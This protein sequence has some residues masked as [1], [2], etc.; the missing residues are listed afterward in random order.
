V[1]RAKGADSGGA[2]PETTRCPPPL[3]PPGC[4][5]TDFKFMPLLVARLRDSDLASEQTPEENWAAVL[6]WAASWHQVPAGSL[7]NVGATIA[8]YAG[9]TAQGRISSR[10]AK[11]K[12]G[13]MRGFVLCSDGRWYHPVIAE[14]ANTAWIHKLQQRFDTEKARI[15][16]HNF[17]HGT[18][19]PYPIWDEWIAAGC[20][21]GGDLHSSSDVTGD[22]RPP[23]NGDKA[24]KGDGEGYRQGTEYSSTPSAPPAAAMSEMARR[25]TPH[26]ISEA[27]TAARPAPVGAPTPTARSSPTPALEQN[28]DRPTNRAWRAYVSAFEERYGVE[29]ERNQQTNG[30]LAQLLR[31]VTADEVPHVIDFYV[32]HK[33]TR[34]YLERRHPIADFVR[35]YHGIRTHWAQLQAGVPDQ[36][37]PGPQS[38]R[39]NRIAG[40][41]GDAA[42]GAPRI[43]SV[44]RSTRDTTD[45]EYRNVQ[46][47]Q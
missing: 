31:R 30:Q 45:V 40:F 44:S 39:A 35:D 9:Y 23:V 24:S 46:T 20:H 21:T 3:T 10:W 43:A 5:L 18:K 17:R 25:S 29:P 32:R 47:L 7:P 42:A 4:D 12:K 37:A 34:S 1:N 14:L 19:V 28:E 22:T 27:K 16:Q 38:Q 26:L 15:K 36:P 13:A 2:V 41:A 33:A 11:V 6:L 8:R